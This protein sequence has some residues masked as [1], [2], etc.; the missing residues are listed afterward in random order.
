MNLRELKA[1]GG[2]IDATPVAKEVEWKHTDDSGNEVTDKFTVHVVRLSFGDVERL[3]ASGS[4][5]SRAA[6]FIER[7]IRL[8]DGTERLSYDDAYALDPGLASVLVQAVNEVNSTGR[9]AEKN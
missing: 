1:K 5:T 9:D 8:G 2:F 6:T 4:D 3:F 7:C